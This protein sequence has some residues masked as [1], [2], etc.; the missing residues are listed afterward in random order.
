M[1][2]CPRCLQSTFVVTL[3]SV[4]CLPGSAP[5]LPISQYADD[6]S[7][8]LTSDDYIKAMF[9]TYALFEK[10]SGAKLNQSKSRCL[11]L[12]S[13]SGCS[14]PPIGLDWSSAKLKI[15]GVFLGVGNL[16]EVNWDPRI[17]AVD[18]VLKFWHSHV[19][20]FLAK[21]W[22]LTLLLSPESDMWLLSFTCLLGF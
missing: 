11:W 5:L 16:E 6:T 21:P 19:L 8:I 15:L 7:L 17:D 20:S 10:A 18:H 2:L 4:V 9:E 14:D 22:L 3:A 12:G 13:W 1:S